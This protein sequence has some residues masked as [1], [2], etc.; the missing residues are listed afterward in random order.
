MATKPPFETTTH[1]VGHSL[2]EIESAL[3][4]V[5]ESIAEPV[6][7]GG[8]KHK[9]QI[10]LILKALGIPEDD[11]I[12]QAWLKIPG[13][14]GLHGMA[15]RNNLDAARPVDDE[16]IERWN[17]MNSILLSV[18]ERFETQYTKVFQT[19][20]DLASKATPAQADV[21]KLKL[22]IPNNRVAHEHFFNTIVSPAWLPLLET[23]GFFKSPPAPEQDLENNG[24]RHMTWPILTYLSKIAKDVPGLVAKILSEIPD[25][26]NGN[27]K[28]GMIEAVTKLPTK[29][30][31]EL[32]P[33]VKIWMNSGG[34][35][36]S[37]MKT[38]ELII[39]LAEDKEI[40]SALWLCLD[41][42]EFV[43]D[44]TPAVPIEGTNYIPTRDPRT[45][46]DQW[47]Y[48]RFLEDDFSTIAAQD[49]MNALVVLT[50]LLSKYI[51]MSR[52]GKEENPPED[53]TYISRP[54]IEKSEHIHRGDADDSLID[55]IL[56]V[57]I[58]VIE[59]DPKILGIII[60]ELRKQRWPV[61]GRI[62]LY[63][64]SKYPDVRPDL[65][66]EALTDIGL[67][68][69][70]NFE[71]EYALLA[72]SGF[73]LLSSEQKKDIFAFIYEAKPKKE[74]ISKYPDPVS[75]ENAQRMV[76]M[77]QRDKLSIF[78]SHFDADVKAHYDEL[79]NELG[80]ADNPRTRERSGVFVGPVSDV[81]ADG[82]AKMSPEEI[83]ELLKTWE[84]PENRH[85]FG[86]S[87]EGLGRELSIAVKKDVARFSTFAMSFVDLDPTYVR[88]Y[89]Q[90]FSESVQNHIPFEWVPIIDL[91]LWIIEQK[92]EIADRTETD[93]WADEDP[94]WG[95]ARRAV[96]SLIS[97][98]LNNNVIP[99]ELYEKVWRIIEVLSDDPDPTPEQELTKEGALIDDAYNLTINTVRGEAMTAVVEYGLWMTRLVEKI[100]EEKRPNLKEFAFFPGVQA[101]LEN[102]FADPS[103]A[104]RAVYGRYLPWIL[105]LG[106]DWTISH[107]KDIFPD[108]E[109]GTPLYDAA[110][111][112][113]IGYVAAYNDVF[114]ILQ[115]QYSEAI[116]QI[117]TEV[118]KKGRRRDRDA[119][120]VEHLMIFF[121][122]GKLDP[123]DPHGLFA[124][125]WQT[126]DEDSRSH[127]IDFLG[128]SLHSLTE[129]LG[130]E[131]A[132]LLKELWET[133]I[134]EAEAAGDKKP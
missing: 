93:A 109:F 25:T 85:G 24:I 20:D 108:G 59:K 76:K 70:S 15:H 92:R 106:H 75:E 124:Q 71:H 107:I 29:Q 40:D 61:F 95:W 54:S 79:V 132:K 111:E 43:P 122:R 90:G 58:E 12:A 80:K 5:L 83:V 99:F 89:I 9:K 112:T 23:G 62:A 87:R 94:H 131:E 105:L 72:E 13:E 47:Q 10:E 65:T 7:P 82:I 32:I 26:E 21:D 11:P 18:L 88:N 133:R 17:T 4:A 64:L 22:H 44:T 2:R 84:P 42:L 116:K 113:Y 16:F 102:H 103:I 60:S 97:N 104:V 35:F 118:N 52:A 38:K 81:S 8:D 119:S 69:E 128:R 114:E 34:Q 68:D 127:A 39:S 121:W 78:S 3:R 50:E 28:A 6:T 19:L 31:V 134:A 14:N 48:A 86:S 67:C 46:I 91:C 73:H 77:W 63:L 110:W 27:V 37:S 33:H 51:D 129:P 120:L 101:I 41:F 56:T 53:Y 100:P 98:G 115:D 96:I 130:D 117:G 57:C 74:R 123:K 45:A 126:A 55:A 1:I 66:I 49:P 36:F 30:K 125:F